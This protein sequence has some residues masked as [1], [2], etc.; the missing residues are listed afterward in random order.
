MAHVAFIPVP[1]RMTCP[2][3]VDTWHTSLCFLLDS[4]PCTWALVATVTW[5][6]RVKALRGELCRVGGGKAVF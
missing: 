4:G 5:K 6:G 2:L 3:E 1:D